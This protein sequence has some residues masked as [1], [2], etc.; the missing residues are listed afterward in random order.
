MAATSGGGRILVT[1]SKDLITVWRD[2]SQLVEQVGIA[3]DMSATLGDT[4]APTRRE[5]AGAAI[6][7]GMMRMVEMRP[8]LGRDVIPADTALGAASIVIKKYSDYLDTLKNEKFF[9]LSL[10]L[11]G[12]YNHSGSQ[13][14]QERFNF[15]T[16]DH[17]QGNRQQSDETNNGHYSSNLFLPMG[18]ILLTNFKA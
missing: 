14:E 9:P 12:G 5:L 4:T 1:P 17:S 18:T 16:R 3:V 11:W 13:S 15:K 6:G 7:P 10:K 8:R 2:R